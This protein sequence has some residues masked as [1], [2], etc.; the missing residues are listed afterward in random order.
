MSWRLKG[1]LAGMCSCK[2]MCR[3]ILGPAE[4][5]QGWCSFAQICEIETGNSNGVDL[6]GMKVAMA[7]DLPG[8][9]FSGVDVARLYIDE[10]ASSEQRRELEAIFTG[11][12]GGVWAAMREVI[13]KWLPAQTTGIEVKWGGS[14]SARVGS[15]GVAKLE[16]LKTGDGKQ[17]RLLNAPVEA[18]F[19]IDTDDLARAD[20][21][22]WSDPEMRRWESGGFGALSP[23]DWSG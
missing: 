5:D 11:E 15:V 8:D 20:G 23:F 1:R 9:F 14:P 21:S 17:T 22:G 6:T 3:C 4:P 7:M 13:R 16:P 12:K 2:M 10:R 19:G 18:A